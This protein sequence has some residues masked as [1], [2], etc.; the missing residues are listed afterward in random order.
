[1]TQPK[2]VAK[3]RRWLAGLLAVMIARPLANP[4]YAALTPLATSR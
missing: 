2:Y 1:M 4:G 3:Y